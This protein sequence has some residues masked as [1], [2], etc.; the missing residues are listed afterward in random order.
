[1]ADRQLK[2]RQTVATFAFE[3]SL[4]PVIYSPRSRGRA[5]AGAWDRMNTEIQKQLG[6]AAGERI[7]NW[8]FGPPQAN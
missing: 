2:V 6:E 3:A 5:L 4:I 1:M 8:L 7:A